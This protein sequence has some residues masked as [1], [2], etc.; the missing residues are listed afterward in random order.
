MARRPHV[1]VAGGGIG[2]LTAALALLQRGFDV[3]VYEQ[4]A[5]LREVGAGLQISANGN[6]AP[7]DA[8]SSLE[9]PSCKRSGARRSSRRR[10]V[11]ILSSAS[12][13]C[14]N[15]IHLRA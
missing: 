14:G 13:S 2:G 15:R 1:L 8:S 9:R 3:N 5:E 6:R 10:W 7:H 11:T 12:V 4:A